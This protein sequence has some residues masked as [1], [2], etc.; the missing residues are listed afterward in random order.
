V[1]TQK[2]LLSRLKAKNRLIYIKDI[3]KIIAEKDLNK[4]IFLDEATM[5]RGHGSRREYYRSRGNSR[6]RP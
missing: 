5:Q 6:V 4:V 1:A 2:P 3:P